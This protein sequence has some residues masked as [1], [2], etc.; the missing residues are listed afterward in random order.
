LREREYVITQKTLKRAVREVR[1]PRLAFYT[2]LSALALGS[3][4]GVSLFVDGAR[5]A[6]PSLLGTGLL[7]VL[8]G[9]GLEY[10]LGTLVPGQ[11][12]RCRVAFEPTR[13]PGV[14]IGDVDI[15]RADQALALLK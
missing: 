11:K 1:Y 12:K 3:F 6:S 13:G 2:G 9:I 10:V 14:C 4:F 5:S 8:V 7:I 15:T